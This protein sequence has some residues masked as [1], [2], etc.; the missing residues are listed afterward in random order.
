MQLFSV[1]FCVV[2]VV[3]KFDFRLV[4]NEPPKNDDRWK[5]HAVIQTRI[6]DMIYMFSP[7]PSS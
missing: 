5:D 3:H 7:R 2:K 6:F 1:L 4:I